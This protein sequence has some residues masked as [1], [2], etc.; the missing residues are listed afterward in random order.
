MTIVRNTVGV[1]VVAFQITFV[2]DPIAVAIIP[3]KLT[4]VRNTRPV[5]VL[6]R[7]AHIRS[8]ILVAIGQV[9]AVIRCAIG[10]A[11]HFTSVDHAIR[12]TV[13]FTIIGN[14]VGIAVVAFGFTTVGQTIAIAIFGR[15]ALIGSSVGITVGQTFAIIRDAVGIAVTGVFAGIGDTVVVTVLLTFVRNTIGIA[16]VSVE[17]AAIRNT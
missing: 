13:R 9:L 8:A 3:I 5:A 1:T 4:A 10:I 11:I 7:F 2:R 17:F 14:P 6:R 12:I 15:L 16:V